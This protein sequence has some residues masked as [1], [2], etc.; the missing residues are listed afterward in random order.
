MGKGVLTW[1]TAG[2]VQDKPEDPDYLEAPGH[3]N[4]TGELS[5][6]VYAL[7]R[8]L[9]R[10][11]TG[12]RTRIYTDSLYTKNM[13]T[14]R[15]M[16][17]RKHRNSALISNLRRLWRR[18]QTQMPG[19][20]DIVHVRSHVE[21]PGNE[22]ADWLADCGSR[23]RPQEQGKSVVSLARTQQWIEQWI[24]Q[25]HRSPEGSRDAHARPPGS[26]EERPHQ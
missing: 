17:K 19:E 6:M 20:V 25:R 13:T 21:I 3:T 14:G 7:R 10:R 5:A 24:R 2:P 23:G 16:P 8:A 1:V 9:T 22:I 15:W 11:H 12:G 26:D 4:N 18:T